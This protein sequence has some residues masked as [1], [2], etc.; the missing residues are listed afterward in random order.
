MRTA[1]SQTRDNYLGVMSDIARVQALKQA[2]ESA[3]TALKAT[4]AGYDVGTRTTV[5]VLAARRNELQALINYQRARYDYVLNSLR[6]QQ[7][8]GILSPEDVAEVATWME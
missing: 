2:Y 6:L 4:Q 3:Q 1:E 7:A 5:D 8:A